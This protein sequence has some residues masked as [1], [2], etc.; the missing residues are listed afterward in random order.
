MRETLGFSEA[1]SRGFDRCYLVDMIAPLLQRAAH[2]I[3]IAGAIINSS[4]TSFA[5]RLMIEHSLDHMRQHT[6]LAHASR[7]TSS[8][9]VE[10]PSRR[11]SH[12]TIQS[13][14]LTIPID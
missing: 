10:G 8:K 5:S 9:I 6:D 1:R 14:L 13:R 11:N 4:H 12:A 2:F 7:Q 3:R